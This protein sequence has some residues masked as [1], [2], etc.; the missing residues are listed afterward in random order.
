[1]K[2]ELLQSLI[3]NEKRLLIKIEVILRHLKKH[4]R[5]FGTVRRLIRFYEMNFMP[6]DITIEN[7]EA[8]TLSRLMS[9]ERLKGKYAE[10]QTQ[11]KLMFLLIVRQ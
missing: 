5:T 6:A 8:K 11:N 9:I 2:D 1:M 4:K 3:T 10:F 7:Y